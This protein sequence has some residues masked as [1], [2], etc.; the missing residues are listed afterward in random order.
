MT[1][2]LISLIAVTVGFAVLVAWVYWPSRR[3]RLE[4]LGQIPLEDADQKDTEKTNE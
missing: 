3:S 1:A 2:T 4:S